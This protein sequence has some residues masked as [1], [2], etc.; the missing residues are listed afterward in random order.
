MW[1]HRGPHAHSQ[2]QD[3]APHNDHADVHRTSHD[4]RA[5]NKCESRKD[6]G[7]LQHTAAQCL[8][9]CACMQS[10]HSTQPCSATGGLSACWH[11]TLSS[12]SL[13][14]SSCVS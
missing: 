5:H 10:L 13:A 8:A 2:A 3:E 6:Q 9:R 11:A 1:P 12:D 4:G 14:S 7:Y